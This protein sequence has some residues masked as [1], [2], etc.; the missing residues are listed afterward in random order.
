M[1][2]WTTVYRSIKKYGLPAL[3]ILTNIAFDIIVALYRPCARNP[4]LCNPVS[5]SIEAMVALL[6]LCLLKGDLRNNIKISSDQFE[7]LN[8]RY[9]NEIKD[10]SGIMKMK[11]RDE[12]RH[13]ISDKR[14]VVMRKEAGMNIIIR[15]LL[16]MTIAELVLAV[17][18]MTKDDP[19][20]VDI[21]SYGF[22]ACWLLEFWHL[23]V[24]YHSERLQKT[25]DNT[26][27][28][29]SLASA[30]TVDHARRGGG[31]SVR[32]DCATQPLLTSDQRFIAE[33]TRSDAGQYP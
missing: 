24:L 2:S 21:R 30:V 32:T 17:L 7:L 26:K 20:V 14:S 22:P 23:H 9:L 5:V 6:T 29:L 19:R 4:D 28:M 10:D 3:L 15:F 12:V 25:I 1:T 16:A 27:S 8:N 31:T 33:N 18:P 13:D 11:Q